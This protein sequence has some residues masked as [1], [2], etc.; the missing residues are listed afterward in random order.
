MKKDCSKE[1]EYPRFVKRMGTG[2]GKQQ[3]VTETSIYRNND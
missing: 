3:K 1:T 2:G